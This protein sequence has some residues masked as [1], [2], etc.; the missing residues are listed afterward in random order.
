MQGYQHTGWH[1]FVAGI[2]GSVLGWE[3]CWPVCGCFRLSVQ[4]D[5]KA[6]PLPPASLIIMPVI[7]LREQRS[8]ERGFT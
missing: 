4:A 5:T 2:A 3:S 8:L 1:F 6:V 7:T